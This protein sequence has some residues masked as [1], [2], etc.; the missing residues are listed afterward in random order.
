MSRVA[1]SSDSISLGVAISG[2]FLVAAVFF[3]IITES[4]QA[5]PASGVYRSHGIATGAKATR[6]RPANVVEAPVPGVATASRPA[7]VNGAQAARLPQKNIVQA[8]VP[9]VVSATDAL[10]SGIPTFP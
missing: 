1:E 3:A 9:G 5:Q 6:G 7:A 2:A 4:V 8:P 10:R